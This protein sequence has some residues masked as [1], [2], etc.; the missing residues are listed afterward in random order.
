IEVHMG[1]LRK[2]LSYSIASPRWI[3][4]LRGVGYRLTATEGE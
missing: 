4:T 2:K 3:E 1:N